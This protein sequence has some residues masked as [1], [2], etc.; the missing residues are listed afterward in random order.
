MRNNWSLIKDRRDDR[1]RAIDLKDRSTVGKWLGHYLS[2][3]TG[4]T[5]GT[6]PRVLLQYSSVLETAKQALSLKS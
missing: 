4:D 1:E 5:A 6:G 2:A 3:E